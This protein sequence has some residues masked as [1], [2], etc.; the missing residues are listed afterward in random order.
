[1]DSRYSHP[2]VSELWSLEWTY[3]AWKRIEVTT[4]VRQRQLLGSPVAQARQETAQM[5]HQLLDDGPK[6][7]HIS[8]RAVDWILAEEA[9]TK[10]DVVAFL[11][12]LRQPFGKTGRWLHYGLTSSD[13]VDTAQGMRFQQIKPTFMDVQ[14]G[15]LSELNR[16]RLDDN[17]I[18][19]RTHGQPAELMTMRARAT[20]WMANAAM[21][22]IDLTKA[23][24]RMAVCK[25]SGPVGTYAHNPPQIE[26]QVAQDL[27]LKPHGFG[28]SQ[29]A[30]RAPLAAW[31]NSA[32]LMVET[33]AKIAMDV[34]L[35]KFTGEGLSI[36]EAEQVGSSSMAHK[37]NPI[38]EE[39]IGG[40]A[41]LA[42]GYALMLQPLD[43]WLERDISSSSVER[44]AVP[45]LWHVL[46]HT[47]ERTTAILRDLQLD[48]WVIDEQIRGSM[49]PMVATRTLQFIADGMDVEEARQQALNTGDLGA[50]PGDVSYAMRNYE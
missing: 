8:N 50:V 17:P 15:L 19:G 24:T 16:W 14:A 6:G 3:N 20:H 30:S 27:R 18:I 49:D 44:V 37:K 39:Q 45:D 5:L 48:P 28:A 38:R 34:R 10:H 1:M 4:L 35:M 29:V 7:H 22:A 12:W 42:R 21:G 9:R 2:V 40:M 33:C 31:A 25:L 47:I 26:S 32:A 36:N 11:G 23:T 46:L 41:R 43:G 13:V